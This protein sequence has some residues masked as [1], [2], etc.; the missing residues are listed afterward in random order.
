MKLKSF[1]L[2]F[3]GVS[4]SFAS[5]AQDVQMKVKAKD[6]DFT[7]YVVMRPALDTLF[8]T[9][10]NI[11]F[12]N[13][14]ITALKIK[15]KGKSR[16]L[17]SNELSNIVAYSLNNKMKERCLISSVKD[18]N[19]WV[20]LSALNT[21]KVRLLYEKRSE[22]FEDEL[23]EEVIKVDYSAFFWR[24]NDQTIPIN[25]SLLQEVIVPSINEC[26]GSKVVGM[27][28]AEDKDYLLE[29]TKYWNA[30]VDC[31]TIIDLN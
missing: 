19:K 2:L 20:W 22:Y 7:G 27:G 21:G 8:G 3:I 28:S 16:S 24:I 30:H 11:S 4:I 14:D 9:I 31:I 13:G 23:T 29:L 18:Q 15:I 5:L 10:Q 1:L 12:S 25:E 17:K 26:V 6:F